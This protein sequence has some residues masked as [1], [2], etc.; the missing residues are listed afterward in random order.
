MDDREIQEID[1]EKNAAVLAA[2]IS[3][4]R[5]VMSGDVRLPERIKKKLESRPKAA[6]EVSEWL[7]GILGEF[8][9]NEYSVA[10]KLAEGLQATKAISTESGIVYVEDY[11]TQHKYLDMAAKLLNLYPPSRQQIGSD[12]AGVVVRL[13]PAFGYAALEEANGGDDDGSAPSD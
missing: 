12:G 6:E 10:A 5:A 7:R 11:F 2:K 1:A 8:A 4:A 13:T 3:L 9:V